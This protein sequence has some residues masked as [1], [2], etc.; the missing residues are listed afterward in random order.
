MADETF[1]EICGSEMLIEKIMPKLGR[2]SLGKQ[3]YKM[4][5]SKPGC[6][7]VKYVKPGELEKK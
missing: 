3:Y 1:C 2:R 6:K 7:N 4:I 5:C